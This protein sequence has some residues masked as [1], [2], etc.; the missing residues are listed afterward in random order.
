[1]A[2]LP[3]LLALLLGLVACEAPPGVYAPPEECVGNGAPEINNLELNSWFDAENEFWVMCIH[4]DWV[5]PFEGASPPNMLGGYISAEVQGFQ[6][7]STWLDDDFIPNPTALGGEVDWI[8]CSEEFQQDSRLDFEMRVRDSCGAASQD[9][10]GEYCIG[11]G[12]CDYTLPAAPHVLE[13]P[14]VGGNGC[15]PRPACID[16]P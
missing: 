15:Q 1:M 9:K 5:D 4:F 14:E 10:S 6:T 13:N 16:L 7:D 12:S 3:L 11:Q 2:R 8:L